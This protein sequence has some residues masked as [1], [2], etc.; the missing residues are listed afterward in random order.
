MP[1]QKPRDRMPWRL[2]VLQAIDRLGKETF[3]L[4]ELY[5]YTDWLGQL[6]PSN[7]NVEAKIRQQLQFLRDE[8]YLDFVDY[9][10]TYRVRRHVSRADS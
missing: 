6:F 2:A 7:L 3:T 10:G 4:Q 1:P 8:G 9:E 5:A